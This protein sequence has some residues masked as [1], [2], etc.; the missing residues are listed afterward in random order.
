MKANIYLSSV[1]CYSKCRTSFRDCSNPQFISSWAEVQA[2]T[3]D[4]ELLSKV[5]DGLAG[6]TP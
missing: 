1:S 2:I 5:E 4:L 6:L 3:W